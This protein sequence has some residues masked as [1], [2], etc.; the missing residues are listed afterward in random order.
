VVVCGRNRKRH[1]ARALDARA[2]PSRQQDS[3]GVPQRVDARVKARARRRIEAAD[4]T[5]A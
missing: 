3:V 2:Y 5:A 1:V 4:I